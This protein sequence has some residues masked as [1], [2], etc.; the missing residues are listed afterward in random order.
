MRIRC[1]QDGDAP[2]LMAFYNCRGPASRRTFRALG[3]D[4]C[5]LSQCAARVAANVEQP[6]RNYDVVA[7]V[8]GR[9]VGWGFVWNLADPDPLFGLV[10][11]DDHQGHG[12][13]RRL[14]EAVLAGTDALGIPEVHLSVVDDNY[15]AIGLYARLGFVDTGSFVHDDGLRYR[16]MVRRRPEPRA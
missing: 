14:A 4:L 12:L 15:L 2:A 1:L 7:D 11:A 13:G 6:R 3:R 10:V 8:D 9:L 16:R 5:D